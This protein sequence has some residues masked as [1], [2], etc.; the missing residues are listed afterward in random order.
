MVCGEGGATD[1]IR[2]ILKKVGINK[3]NISVCILTMLKLILM[4]LFSSDYQNNMF[5]PFVSYF[6]NEGNNPYQ[7]FYD[8]GELKAFPYPVVMLLIQSTGILIIKLFKISS[9]FMSNI[10]FKLPSLFFDFLGLYFITKMFPDKRKYAIVLYFASPIILYSV[11]M[12][13]QLDLIP[14]VFLLCSVYFLSSKD[15]YIYTWG[16]YFLYVHC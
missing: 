7:Y 2:C 14:T 10:V 11:Y 3:F 13:G 12:H 8:M 5:I 4:G 1:M 16:G 15:K 9:T 6:V